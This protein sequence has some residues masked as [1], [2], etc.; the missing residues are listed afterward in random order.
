MIRLTLIFCLLTTV[1]A[2]AQQ[3]QYSWKIGLHGGLSY[4]HGDINERF[5]DIPQH[6]S[7]PLNGLN[8]L[9]YG[10]S[11][12]R[13][14]TR[15]F[16]LRLTA[17][18]SQFKGR[19]R[20][21]E[22]NIDYERS[23]NVQTDV[24]DGSLVG[25]F[26]FDNGKIFGARA[27]VSP[28]VLIGGGLMHFTPKGDLL[29]A[30]GDRYY[31]WQDRT[32]RDLSQ[33]DPNASS[34]N[35]IERD[36]VYETNLAE[37]RTE[38]TDY[39]QLTWAVVFGFGFKVR[40]TDR[41]Y[42]HG[43]ALL[44][45]TGTDYLDD[46]AS[47]YPDTYDNSFQAY[48]SN[49]NNQTAPRGNSPG[50][51]DWFGQGLISVHYSFGQNTH[52]VRTSMIYTPSLGMRSY[53]REASDE[54][55]ATTAEQNT[56][57][58][59]KKSSLP[60]RTSRVDTQRVIKVTKVTTTTVTETTID[61]GYQSGQPV[62]P[63][64]TDR[65]SI[66]PAP[67]TELDYL[68]NELDSAFYTNVLLDVEEE[69][70]DSLFET[71]YQRDN[72]TPAWMA[73][74]L[75]KETDVVPT[76][77]VTEQ[78]IEPPLVERLLE[79]SIQQV[80]PPSNLASQPDSTQLGT[81]VAVTPATV[82][83]Q[84]LPPDSLRLLQQYRYKMEAER[85]RF[86][87]TLKEQQTRYQYELQLQALQNQIAQERAKAAALSANAT[88][89]RSDSV[90]IR[91]VTVP[92]V[93]VPTA[94]EANTTNTLDEAQ[95]QS[96]QRQLEQQQQELQAL[97]Q[98]LLQ[99]NNPA[100]NQDAGSY[101]RTRWNALNADLQRQQEELAALRQQ[102]QQSNN[103]PSTTPAVLP[104]PL[105]TND[106]E[107]RRALDQL[108]ER[109][110]ALRLQLETLEAERIAL[111]PA[112]TDTVVLAEPDP[113]VAEQQRLIEDLRQQL[114][115]IQNEREAISGTLQEFLNRENPSYVTKI[116][117]DVGRSKLSL[118][119]QENL[120]SL[121]AYLQNYPTVNFWVKGY[122][123][124][125]GSTAVNQ[126][127]SKERA[128]AVYNYLRSQGIAAAR[129]QQTAYGE[130]HGGLRHELDRRAEIHLSFSK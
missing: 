113:R 109:E 106:G 82:E 49:P 19:D 84:P 6:F 62:L 68:P 11:L 115:N 95:L 33:S 10:L 85:E 94:N 87:Q 23:L 77:L 73:Y 75:E 54:T 5:W 20:R 53:E 8:F 46:V 7:E 102:L 126:R 22:S 104:V 47:D 31:Y 13:H 76:T 42:I 120:T 101:D 2:K 78:R 12:E 125:T 41:I 80:S 107:N 44:R 38:G 14:F 71:Q 64:N 15:S 30:N 25:V 1:T 119:A 32:I 37:L 123:S 98:A 55:A 26:Y 34:A 58:A 86:K 88:P 60:N 51:T 39:S 61:S 91:Q 17:L 118:Q 100:P 4:Y 63:S 74:A 9:T 121:V 24:V 57:V 72:P 65:S 79:D 52:P 3:H 56:P 50:N 28:Y 48:A 93:A 116:Y 18:K 21:Y 114:R 99:K 45:Y 36:Y 59:E 97:R 105:P 92:N 129:L 89:V 29:D 67:P 83:L 124:P 96:L 81:P 27:A 69:V 70:L 128:A 90:R 108:M 103:A 112:T 111:P 43:E 35:I 40:V 16:A 117:F 127:L 130:R 66:V 110:T 122:A